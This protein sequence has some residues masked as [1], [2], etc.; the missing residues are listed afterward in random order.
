MPSAAT[1]GLLC[2]ALDVDK[3]LR[4]STVRRTLSTRDRTLI[5]DIST[6]ELRLIR[7]VTKSFMDMA[8]LGARALNEFQDDALSAE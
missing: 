4:P 2:R 5:A 7:I 1:A 3:E 6:T 8:V